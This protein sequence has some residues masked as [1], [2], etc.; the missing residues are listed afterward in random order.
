[1]LLHK[2]LHY[3]YI[4]TD[5]NDKG[6]IINNTFITYVEPLLDDF[7]NNALLQEWKLNLDDAAHEKKI[8]ANLYKNLYKKGID[9]NYRYLYWTTSIRET[10]QLFPFLTIIEHT[11]NVL[12]PDK[13]LINSLLKV[14]SMFKLSL[15]YDRYNGEVNIVDTI[16]IRCS[17]FNKETGLNLKDTTVE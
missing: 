14:F 7:N 15:F 17:N 9:F 8:Y 3:S 10:V 4:Q 5:Y 16:A 6:E 1:M 2:S 13:G 11:E 12:N